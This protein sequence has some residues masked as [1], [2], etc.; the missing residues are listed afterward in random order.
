MYQQYLNDF[1]IGR[2]NATVKKIHMYTKACLK[3]GII[4]KDPTHKA[5]VKGTKENKNETVKFLNDSE[6]GKLIKFVENKLNP[7]YPSHY[8]ILFAVAAECRLFEILGLTRDCIS[9]KEGL[10]TINKT[11]DYLKLHN[12]DKT[13]KHC[14]NKNHKYRP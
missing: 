2:A 8:I 1:G 12:F 10:I 5:I 3:D 11:W 7:K 6:T 13:K 9:F 4:F 14:V